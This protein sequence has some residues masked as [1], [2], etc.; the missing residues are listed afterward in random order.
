MERGN[1]ERLN[2]SNFSSS[3][4][5]ARGLSFLDVAHYKHKVSDICNDVWK[6]TPTTASRASFNTNIKNS[7]I[8]RLEDEGFIEFDSHKQFVESCMP[9]PIGS[10]LFVQKNLIG[11]PRLYQEQINH[12]DIIRNVQDFP[13]LKSEIESKSSKPQTFGRDFNALDEID[14]IRTQTINGRDFTFSKAFITGEQSSETWKKV[15]DTADDVR[16]GLRSLMDLQ[17]EYGGFIAHHEIVQATG[18]NSRAVNRL[19]RSRPYGYF[20]ENT[21]S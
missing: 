8:P 7:I 4:L 18:W 15:L 5:L 20:S 1:K 3:I 11:I 12:F 19:I 21:Y 13:E 2:P 6:I 14:A 9:Y 17:G 10:K 16:I